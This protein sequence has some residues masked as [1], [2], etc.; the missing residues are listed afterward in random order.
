M[1]D[2]LFKGIRTK[3]ALAAGGETRIQRKLTHLPPL[4]AASLFLMPNPMILLHV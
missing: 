4:P 3:A 2:L 1:I